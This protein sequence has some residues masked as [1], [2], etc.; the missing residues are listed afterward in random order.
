MTAFPD[1]RPEE[2]E[3]FWTRAKTRGKLSVAPGYMAQDEDTFLEPPA[4]ALGDGTSQLADTLA[5]LVLA[6]EKSATSSYLPSYEAEGVEPPQVGDLAILLDGQA[7]PVALIRNREV[8][9]LPFSD[10]GEELATLEG[11]DL[12]SW[13]EAHRTIFESEARE[14]GTEFGEGES[15]VVEIFDVLYRSDRDHT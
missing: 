13:R 2:L 10:V 12:E 15:V 4:F 14:N 11:S 7:H 5:Q 3:A 6:G 1:P 9:V 8:R